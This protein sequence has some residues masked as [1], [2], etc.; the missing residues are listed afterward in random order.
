MLCSRAAWGIRQRDRT[1]VLDNLKR[2]IILVLP[3]PSLRVR[4]DY[5]GPGHRQDA[6]PMEGDLDERYSIIIAPDNQQATILGESDATVTG[7]IVVTER[8]LQF[9]R[10]FAPEVRI[11]R[12]MAQCTLKRLDP[13]LKFVDPFEEYNL[14]IPE[15]CYRIT[16]QSPS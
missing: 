10:M 15:L 14:M 1:K 12:R 2:G 16:V 8:Q 5:A 3:R 7:I 6:F 4:N 13:G 9:P 11:R